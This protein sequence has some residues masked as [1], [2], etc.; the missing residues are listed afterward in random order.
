MPNRFLGQ[1]VFLCHGQTKY[2]NVF[3]DLTE[4]GIKTIKKTAVLIPFI[5]GNQNIAIFSSPKIRALGSA[6]IIA[7]EL[8]IRQKIIETPKLSAIEI[9]DK[10]RAKELFDEFFR[11]GIQ[12]YSIAYGTDPR[13]EDGVIV[14]PRSAVQKRFFS[15]FSDLAKWFMANMNSP[16]R[17]VAVSHYEVLCHLVESAFNLN[18][19]TD[20]PLEYGEIIMVSIYGGIKNTVIIEITFR[21]KTLKKIFDYKRER[22]L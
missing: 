17:I 18:Y 20:D 5:N 9:R 13:L 11:K 12:A 6:S 1:A 15:F 2:T 21:K 14:E 4:E 22:F 7:K 3:P 16:L 19:E 8:D 10:K